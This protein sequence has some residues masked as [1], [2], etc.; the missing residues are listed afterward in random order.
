MPKRES[1]QEARLTLAISVTREEK[2]LIEEEAA[3]AKQTISAFACTAINNLIAAP[4]IN[5]MP[6]L[7]GAGYMCVP[8]GPEEY[9]YVPRNWDAN[10]MERAARFYRG[11]ED[12]TA[13][14]PTKGRGK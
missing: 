7:P 4:R 14:V 11:L 12:S 6:M 5:D 13:A 1:T 8:T 2:V 10:S 9:I 3:R